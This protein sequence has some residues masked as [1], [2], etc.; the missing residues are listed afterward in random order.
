MVQGRFTTN[1][2]IE[3]VQQT[4]DLQQTQRERERKTIIGAYVI[5][6]NSC[7]GFTMAIFNAERASAVPHAAAAVQN[8]I[9]LTTERVECALNTHKSARA[10][11]IYK[12]RCTLHPS[13]S[14]Y[15]CLFVR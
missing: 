13:T 6:G 5:Q 3:R 15:T 4:K 14:L 7:D 11:Q 1:A 12:P 2:E 9:P 10:Y 8:D